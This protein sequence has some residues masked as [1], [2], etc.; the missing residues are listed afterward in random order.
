MYHDIPSGNLI[1]ALF[2]N[3]VNNYACFILH[4]VFMRYAP[5]SAEALQLL[6]ELQGDP[7]V[8]AARWGAVSDALLQ[9]PFRSE[10]VLLAL[11]L[12]DKERA[13]FRSGQDGLWIHRNVLGMLTLRSRRP[14][15]FVL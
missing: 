10:A 13:L 7:A 1:C 3:L 14:L 4:D 6:L 15:T 12:T 11:R 2:K 5:Q 9:R 8:K